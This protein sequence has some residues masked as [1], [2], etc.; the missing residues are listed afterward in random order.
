MRHTRRVRRLGELEW[1]EVAYRVYLA[2]LVGG[3]IVIWLSGLVT[4][5]PATAEE[6]ANVTTHGPAVLGAFVAISIALGLRS[7]SDG[8]P[9]ALEGADVRHL[10]LAPIARRN[11]L[12]QPVVQ[13][14]RTMAFGGAL[15][16]A[17]AGE[18]AARRLPGSGPAWAAAAAL[19]GAATGLLFVAVAVLTHV[20]HVPRWAATTIAALVLGPQAGADRRMV[21]RTGR[22]HRQ[23]RPLGD[24]AGTDRPDLRSPSSSRSPPPPWPLPAACASNRSSGAP[25]SSRSCASP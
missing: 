6:I 2:A 13:R 4:D 14:L 16:A 1:F 18:L 11:V 15:V 22:R 19:A 12:T 8:G 25:I 21:A 10:L 3:G 7:G 17:L 23:P 24:A 9:I 20:L 5:E